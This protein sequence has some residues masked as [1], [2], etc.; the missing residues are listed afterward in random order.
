MKGRC[1][2]NLFSSAH[3]WLKR[4]CF[5]RHIKG[6]KVFVYGGE[7][8]MQKTFVLLHTC[9]VDSHQPLCACCLARCQLHLCRIPCIAEGGRGGG[10][11]GCPMSRCVLSA[12]LFVNCIYVLYSAL[13]KEE[14]GRG[15]N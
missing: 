15:K 13:R 2:R 12:S 14:G 9:A 11:G 6:V 10:G 1:E 7:R 5:C 4:F 8:E 3:K